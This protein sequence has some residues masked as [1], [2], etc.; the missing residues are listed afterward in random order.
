MT[1]AYHCLHRLLCHFMGWVCCRFFWQSPVLTCASA[2][3]LA[4][5]LKGITCTMQDGQ[6]YGFC[7]N[8]QNVRSTIEHFQ[9]TRTAVL[10]CRHVSVALTAL[11]SFVSVALTAVLFPSLLSANRV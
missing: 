3:L 7:R 11:F 8:L 4:L 9:V 5:V 6:Y 2:R 10:F 1:L